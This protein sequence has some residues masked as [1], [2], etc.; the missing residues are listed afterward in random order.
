M[1]I[2]LIIFIIIH[3]GVFAFTVEM[4]R[5]LA[6]RHREYPLDENRE[7]LP[8]GFLRLRYIVV[9]FIVGYIVWV[10]FSFWL[11]NLF[12]GDLL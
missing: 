3:L 1:S 6:Y 5:R 8:F 11:Y 7:T 2:S 10:L 4:L 12:I 9:A